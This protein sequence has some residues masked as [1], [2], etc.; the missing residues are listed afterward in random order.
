MSGTVM[1]RVRAL[2]EDPS[3]SLARSTTGT[4]RGTAYAPGSGLPPDTEWR[5]PRPQIS[6]PSEL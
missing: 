6:E 5:V 1:T 3:S 4:A 2:P